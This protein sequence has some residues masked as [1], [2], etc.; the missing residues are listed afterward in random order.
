VHDD[1]HVGGTPVRIA[2]EIWEQWG[3]LAQDDEPVMLLRFAPAG[4]HGLAAR[5]VRESVLEV[6]DA[7]QAEIDRSGDPNPPFVGEWDWLRVSDGVLVKVIECD[8]M[9]VVLPAVATALERRGVEGNFEFQDWPTAGTPPTTA[10]E[11]ECRVRVR[12]RRLRRGAGDYLWQ[13]DPAAHAAVLETADDW[14]RRRGEHATYSMSKGTIGPVPVEP[15]EVV[16]DRMVE[17]V[18]D[19]KPAEVSCLMADRFRAFAARPW[20]GGVSLV[21]GGAS[22]EGDAWR[23]GV[24]EL[25]NLLRDCADLLA[26]GFVKRGWMVG[27]ALVS[28]SLPLDWPAR[29]DHAPRGIGFTGEAFEDVYAPDAFGVQLLGPGYTDRL[30]TSTSWRQERVGGAAVL[31]EHGDPSA[32][33]DAPFVP[34]GARVRTGELPPPAV[35]AQARDELRRVLYAPGAL[36]RAGYDEGEL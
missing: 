36:S 12:G 3:P 17:A 22:V 33:F 2:E 10:H 25:T 13:V 24:A 34:F 6:T 35:L 26:Y 16:V 5:A 31:L 11:L 19:R 1:V 4:D 20:S 15:G 14:C 30:P 8:R 28:N 21:M 23:A 27:Q 9:Q 18:A 32:W 29:L 7:F